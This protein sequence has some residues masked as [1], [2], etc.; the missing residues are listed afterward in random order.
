M[1]IER[2]AVYSAGAGTAVIGVPWAPSPGRADPPHRPMRQGTQDSQSGSR[3]PRIAAVRVLVVTGLYPP[4]QVGGYEIACASFVEHL[5]RS[6]HDV[7]VLAAKHP[8]P[9][10]AADETAVF[11]GLEWYR[12]ETL[13]FRGL[14]PTG[15]LRLERHNQRTLISQLT[16]FGPEVVNWWGMGGMSLSLLATVRRAGI[17]AIGMVSD[18]WMVYAPK[19]DGWIRAFGPRP[20]LGRVVQ[21][22][23][24]VPTTLNYAQAASWSFVSKHLLRSVVD[25]GVQVRSALIGHTGVNR[26]ELHPRP[27]RERFDGRLL[28]VGRVAEVKGVDVAVRAIARLPPSY[29][30]TI[31]GAADVPYAAMLRTI[32]REEGVSDRVSFAPPTSRSGLSDVYGRSDALL[33]PVR[34][35]EPWGLVPLE[36]MACGLPVIA[37]GTGGSAEYLADGDNCLLA[38]RGDHRALAEAVKRLAADQGLRRRLREHG[39]GTA[40][41]F[42]EQRCNAIFEGQLLSVVS[43]RA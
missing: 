32:C 15:R 31:V 29:T 16:D 22:L 12:D 8:I 35:D 21:R 17:P 38:K 26:A 36:A 4:N 18:E 23:T 7:R 37:T 34:W 24:G 41:R 14:S 1:Q 33:F 25:Q 20:W 3:G 5:R 13:R 19:V 39:L 30:L 42:P 43:G 28:Y 10:G 11:R 2:V 9:A 6:G 40:D 27:T